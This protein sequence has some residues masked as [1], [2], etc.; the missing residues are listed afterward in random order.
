M[1]LWRHAQLV[2]VHG[3]LMDDANGTFAAANIASLHANLMLGGKLVVPSVATE[4]T[5]SLT[6]SGCVSGRLLG[7]NLDSLTTTVGWAL[8]PLHNAILL[9]EAVNMELGHIDRQLTMLTRSGALAG[10][11]AVALGQ[12]TGF[13]PSK[14][15]SVVDLLREHLGALRVPTLGGLPPGHGEAPWSVPI[16]AIATLDALARQLAVQGS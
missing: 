15:C 10:V 14:G 2:T 4:L 3:A 9:L 13:K 8:P 1:S 6:T 5:T 16:G 7:G 12:F 11:A